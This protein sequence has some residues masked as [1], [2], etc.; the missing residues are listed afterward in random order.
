MSPT[1][2]FTNTMLGTN[3]GANETDQLY[4]IIL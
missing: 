1:L 3:H 2:L 4:I